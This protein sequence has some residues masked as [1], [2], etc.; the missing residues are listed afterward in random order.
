L[1][2]K[3]IKIIYPCVSEIIKIDQRINIDKNRFINTDNLNSR[4]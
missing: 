4:K 2:L 3:S 1:I